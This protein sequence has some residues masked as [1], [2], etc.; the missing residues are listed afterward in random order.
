MKVSQ[1]VSQYQANYY[2]TAHQYFMDD[3][4]FYFYIMHFCSAFTP[5]RGCVSAV[6]RPPPSKGYGV[7]RHLAVDT[8]TLFLFALCES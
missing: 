5:C 4:G 7:D 3:S 1:K 8:D 2:A 6:M